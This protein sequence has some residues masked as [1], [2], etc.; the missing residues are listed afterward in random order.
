[1]AWKYSSLFH[2]NE[3]KSF[4]KQPLL[5]RIDDHPVEDE[6]DTTGIPLDSVTEIELQEDTDGV[7]DDHPEL[8]ENV[9]RTISTPVFHT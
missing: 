6:V 8:E 5:L 9:L 4:A 2:G 3:R 7:L 1:M